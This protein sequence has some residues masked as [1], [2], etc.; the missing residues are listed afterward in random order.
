MATLWFVNGTDVVRLLFS[1]A[2]RLHLSLP[3]DD[4]KW[5]LSIGFRA[6]MSAHE[7]LTLFMAAQEKRSFMW[8]TTCIEVR[9]NFDMMVE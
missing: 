4:H 9:H 2:P 3:G 5:P 8:L 7:S 1:D 6:N